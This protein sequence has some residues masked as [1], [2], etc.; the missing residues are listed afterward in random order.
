[1]VQFSSNIDDG[2]VIMVVWD[3]SYFCHDHNG[4][5]VGS[6]GIEQH[7]WKNREL[8]APFPSLN[9]FHE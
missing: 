8:V 4:D 5:D 6:G 1:M 7:R 2:M 9:P 3:N